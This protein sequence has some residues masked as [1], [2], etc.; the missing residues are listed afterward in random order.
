MPYPRR[1]L[2]A[3]TGLTPQVVTE[4]VYALFREGGPLPTEIHVLSTAK[5]CDEARRALLGEDP[6]WFRRLCRDYRLPPIAFDETCLHTLEDAAGEPLEDIRTREDNDRAADGIAEQVRC[7]TEDRDSALHVS[8]AGGRKTMGFYAGYALSLFGRPQDRLSHV[9]VSPPYE[10]LVGFFYPT[11]NSEKLL[12]RDN[13]EVDAHEAR[14]TL[15][16]IPFLRLRRYMPESLLSDAAR[17]STIVRAAQ[18]ALGPTELRIDYSR[19]RL[20]AGGITIKLA[21]ID[22][23]FYGWLVR[24]NLAGL[25]PVRRP[26]RKDRPQEHDE[27]VRAFLAEYTRLGDEMDQR[28]DRTVRILGEEKGMT[29]AW[30]DER[31]SHINRKLKQS[32]AHAASAYLI[33]DSGR[34]R[35]KCYWL[36]LK[37]EQIHF[38]PVTSL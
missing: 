9:L 7:L 10:S 32:L 12:L 29:D 6:G 33:T 25:E 17:F 4:T 24:R 37:P 8:L 3:V 5:G 23:A 30:F 16:D 26:N 38:D 14:V 27:Y 19:R 2:L 15:A 28:P 22:L 35:G 13:R 11:P 20:I 18:R 21:P 34:Q 31:R 36:A 1:I